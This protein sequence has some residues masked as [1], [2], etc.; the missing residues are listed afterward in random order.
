[1]KIKILVVKYYIRSQLSLF[2][3]WIL[4][5]FHLNVDIENYGGY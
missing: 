1:M 4:E 3:Q 2:L 5:N